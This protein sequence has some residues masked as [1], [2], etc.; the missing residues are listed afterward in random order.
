MSFDLK[1]VS[2]KQHRD[3]SCFLSILPPC[4]FGLEHLVHLHLKYLLIIVFLLTFCSLFFGCFCSSSLFLP[5]SLGLF[6]FGC[7]DFFSVL[8]RF[9]SLYFLCIF[10]RFLVCS[11]HE[12]HIYPPILLWKYYI[13]IPQLHTLFLTWYLR[14]FCFC[15]WWVFPTIV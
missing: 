14:S 7:L 13:F 9:L 8:F 15:I 12:V 2:C 10:H 4:A 5:S 3:G 6:P 11:Y 1:W